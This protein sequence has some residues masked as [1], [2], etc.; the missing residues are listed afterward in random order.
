M[1]ISIGSDAF[2]GL[3]IVK[4]GL[5]DRQTDR[6]CYFVCNNRPNLCT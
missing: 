2:A 3:T 4:D 5:T 6:P 1:G